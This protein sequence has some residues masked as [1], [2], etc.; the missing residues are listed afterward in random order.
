[1][2]YWLEGPLIVGGCL[3]AEN[4]DFNTLGGV[5]CSSGSEPEISDHGLV[6]FGD[7]EVF[8]IAVNGHGA[9]RGGSSDTSAIQKLTSGCQVQTFSEYWGDTTISDA[10]DAALRASVIF[11]NYLPNYVMDSRGTVTKMRDTTRDEFAVFTFDPCDSSTVF[12]VPPLSSLHYSDASGFLYND[13]STFNGLQGDLPP[14]GVTVVFNIPILHGTDLTILNNKIAKS[15]TSPCHTIFNIYPVD[16][17]GNYHFSDGIVFYRD[18]AGIMPGFILAPRVSIVDS[19][20]GYFQGQI[21][22]NSYQWASDSPGANIRRFDQSPQLYPFTVYVREPT[23]TVLTGATVTISPHKK[24]KHHDKVKEWGK[25][26]YSEWDHKKEDYDNWDTGK[27]GWSEKGGGYN[28]DWKEDK[29][30]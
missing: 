14:E 20:N 18:F 7:T 12:C 21:V 27:Y 6:V 8:N 23:K 16:M 15:V 25:K 29:K 4:Y 1:M 22:G 2:D 9:L 5:D 10:E 30:W 17:A 13:D 19:A 3:R 11:S 24:E 26:K 28:R